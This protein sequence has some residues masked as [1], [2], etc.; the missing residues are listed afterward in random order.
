MLSRMS[1]AMFKG[2]SPDQRRHGRAPS[3]CARRRIDPFG[4]NRTIDRTPAATALHARNRGDA[5]APLV[6][7]E[8]NRPSSVQDKQDLSLRPANNPKHAPNT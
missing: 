8:F 2:A 4:D 5:L 7:Q 6:R 1:S 3:K